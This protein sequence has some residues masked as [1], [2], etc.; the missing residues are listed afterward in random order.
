MQVQI[1]NLCN[2]Q[3]SAARTCYF[4]VTV[5]ESLVTVEASTLRDARSGSGSAT[6]YANVFIDFLHFWVVL[7]FFALRVPYL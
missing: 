7:S 2:H 5:V 6:Y 4:F 1:K 3:V